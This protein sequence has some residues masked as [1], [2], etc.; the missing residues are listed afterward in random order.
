MRYRGSTVRRK[1]H[2]SGFILLAIFLMAGL[3]AITLYQQL[4]RIAFESERDKEQLLIERGEEYVRAIQLY[5]QDNGGRWP[6]TID[7]L[8]RTNNKRYLR[9]R[10]VDPYTG[11]N[12]WRLIHTNGQQLTDSLVQKPPVTGNQSSSSSS[13]SSTSANSQEAVQVNQAV[14]ARPSDLTLPNSQSF[15]APAPLS[16]DI[17]ANVPQGLTPQ[18]I[19][20][21]AGIGNVPPPGSVQPQ[22]PGQQFPGQQF[23]GQQV[24]GQGLQ[25]P[26]QQFPGQQVPGQPANGPQPQFPGQQIPGQQQNVNTGQTN[27]PVPPGFQL[28]PNGTLVP[29]PI[30]GNAPLPPSNLPQG[31]FPPGMNTASAVGLPGGGGNPGLDTINRILTNQPAAQTGPTVLSNNAVGGGGIAGIASTHKGPSIKVYKDRSKYQEWEFIFTP[32]AGVGGVGGR[33]GTGVPGGNNGNNG[34]R[35]GQNGPGG[36]NGPTQGGGNGPGGGTSGFTP[37]GFSSGF[38]NNPGGQGNGPGGGGF[39]GNQPAPAGGGRGR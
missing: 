24:P 1:K 19:A 35:G 21:Q 27:V 38:G 10:Y 25:F 29:A 34:G 8:E 16:N 6:Q 30:G 7:E 26:G 23:P 22:F 20:A 33:G 18:Q 4:P 9:K 39:G 5:Y 17:N 28:G 32:T 11:K 36:N 31:N 14:L 13:S 2:Q 12:E 15:N 3:V 37:S